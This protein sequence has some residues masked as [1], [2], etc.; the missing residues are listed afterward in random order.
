MSATIRDLHF[1]LP[2]LSDVKIERYIYIKNPP[3]KTIYKSGEV[4]DKT[5]LEIELVYTNGDKELITNYTLSINNGTKLTLKN[6]FIIIKYIC[7]DG[8][9]LSTI[10]P[11]KIIPNVTSF[12][13]GSIEN[14]KLMLED[15]DT[16]II[17][18]KD[19]WSV[20]ES[21][22]Y[23]NALFNENNTYQKYYIKFVIYDLDKTTS[24]GTKYH[25]I[26]GNTTCPQ[27]NTVYE[28][29]SSNYSGCPENL[30]NTYLGTYANKTMI[31]ST[32]KYFIKRVGD[33]LSSLIIPSSH[34]VGVYN[35]PDEIQE[36]KDVKYTLISEYEFIGKCIYSSP[37]EAVKCTQL[38]YFKDYENR[39][40]FYYNNYGNFDVIKYYLATR[41]T[42]MGYANY[43]L[44][45]FDINGCI[46]DSNTN[47]ARQFLL[48]C[49]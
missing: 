30:K 20:G 21:R 40:N 10:L 35:K 32:D 48:F 39:R 13:G 28:L 49:I 34:V 14:I 42:F 27:C 45:R 38:E 24:G 8:T 36:V 19:Y 47:K 1:E 25:A 23:R 9:E 22:E 29:S 7:T 41:S 4:F 15:V 46:T 5:G 44:I 2:P 16:G 11:L 6:Y 18:I 26:I 43:G 31:E 37:A 33:D 17:N 12:S 3:N